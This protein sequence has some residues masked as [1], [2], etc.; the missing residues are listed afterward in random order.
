MPPAVTVTGIWSR[1]QTPNKIT[2]CVLVFPNSNF[3]PLL[4][5]NRWPII[6]A[7][8]HV[9]IFEALKKIKL[10]D[11]VNLRNNH[12]YVSSFSIE[13]FTDSI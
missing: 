9:K 4:P 3:V 11:L 6:P 5:F 7:C 1:F 2:S 13:Q 10:N 12:T 8:H